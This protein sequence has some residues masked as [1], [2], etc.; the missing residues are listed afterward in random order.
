[1]VRVRVKVKGQGQGQGQGQLKAKV[2][3]RVR[4]EV[5][6]ARTSA[7][8]PYL[9]SARHRP[10]ARV[11]YIVKQARSK[12]PGSPTRQKHP[13]TY[14]F[15]CRRSVCSLRENF[16][17]WL[18]AVFSSFASAKEMPQDTPIPSACFRGR[19]RNGF[20]E[21]LGLGSELM[22]SYVWPLLISV[23]LGLG[24]GVRGRGLG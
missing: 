3:V 1:M 12:E 13:F 20:S 6:R 18:F 15:S 8:V 24:L 16:S 21:E 11:R 5:N 17:K 23:E 10:R 14:V 19:V 22:V 4:V 9:C 2:R 7:C